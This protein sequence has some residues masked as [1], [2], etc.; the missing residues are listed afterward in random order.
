MDWNVIVAFVAAL[1][2]FAAAAWRILEERSVLRRFESLAT[3]RAVLPD[4]HKSI[5]HLDIALLELSA[6]IMTSESPGARTNRRWIVA[7]LISG[8]SFVS[9]GFSY[10][11]GL[12]KNGPLNGWEI[13]WTFGSMLLGVASTL[14][15]VV[16][17]ALEALKLFFNA[18]KA[19][20][21]SGPKEESR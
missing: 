16:V 9:F 10:A 4:G 15:V 13:L 18:K 14:M 19:A 21:K 1:L 3:S 2:V 11:W 5:A 12:G 8:I 17:E 7:F 6:R 20:Q